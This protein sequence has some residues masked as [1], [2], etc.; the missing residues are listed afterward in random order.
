MRDMPKDR[1][2]ELSSLVSSVTIGLG[3]PLPAPEEPEPDPPGPLHV[4]IAKSVVKA[5][6]KCLFEALPFL[7]KVA[8]VLVVW[9][10]LGKFFQS[11]ELRNRDVI[12]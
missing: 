10:M 3:A 6:R 12:S 5:F 7:V 4:W 11:I 2:P 1:S 8:A 9:A